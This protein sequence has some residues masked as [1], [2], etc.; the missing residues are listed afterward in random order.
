MHAW[1]PCRAQPGSYR[2]PEDRDEG[3]QA[4]QESPEH[5]PRGAGTDRV[6]GGLA[7]VS[8]VLIA[9]SGPWPPSR[10]R[11]MGTPATWAGT[12]VSL[13]RPERP[14]GP[15]RL[16]ITIEVNGESPGRR[17]GV[18]RSDEEDQR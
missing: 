17:P 7:V 9:R 1:P 15:V 13:M 11:Q 16:T 5:A 3:Q 12:L 14:I 2:Q 4:E 18:P 10:P 8:A 6:V